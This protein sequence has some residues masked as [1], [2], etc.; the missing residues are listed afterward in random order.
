[1]QLR[2]ISNKAIYLAI[3]SKIGIG[4]KLDR[5]TGASYQPFGKIQQANAQPGTNIDNLSLSVALFGKFDQKACC[6]FYIY[7][8]TYSAQ[9]TGMEY[10][11]CRV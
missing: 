1:M 6:F 2:G 8:V 5:K 7:E 4:P 3:A 11:S 9:V 10:T